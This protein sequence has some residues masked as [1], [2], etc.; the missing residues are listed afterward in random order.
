MK[1]PLRLPVGFPFVTLGKNAFSLNMMRG[2]K[3]SLKYAYNPINYFSTFSE[4]NSTL[5]KMIK[6]ITPVS[7]IP[8]NWVY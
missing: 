2:L 4:K 5:W 6:F 1:S 7:H 3:F 8:I